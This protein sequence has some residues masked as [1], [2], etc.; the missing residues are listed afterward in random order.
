ME[1][2]KLRTTCRLCGSERLEEIFS[3]GEQCISAFVET[4]SEPI[5]APLT[6][7]ECKRC[8]LLQLKHTLSSDILYND[9]YG[10]KTSLNERMVLEMRQ[11]VEAIQRKIIL[12]EG[13]MVVDI[14]SNDGTL[15]TFYPTNLIRVGFDPVKKFAHEVASKRITHVSDYFNA[16][17][18]KGK[19]RVITAIAM[20]YDLDEPNKFLEDINEVLSDDG[21]F[22]IQQNYL[23]KM[24]DEATYDNISHEHLTYYSLKTLQ[25]LLRRHNLEVVDITFS[26]I[27]GGCFRTFIQKSSVIAPEDGVMRVLDAENA[28]REPDYEYFKR[29]TEANIDQIRD[30]ILGEYEKGKK[31]FILGASTRGNVILNATGLKYPI[32]QAASERNPEK[33]GKRILGTNIPIINEED[34]RKAKPDYFLVLPRWYRTEIIE[35][36]DKFLKEGGKL[37]F[38][39]PFGV[40]SND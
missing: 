28:E 21:L 25:E 6:L 11:I 17:W 35:R 8:H 33:W 38:P 19:A 10:Y 30:F 36:E 34:A 13:D 31:I 23:P 27:N 2:V 1:N 14:G 26:P 18:F 39:I 9:N 24:I 15:L 3:L 7:V 37:I 5:L 20:F 4:E 22:V 29:R 32:L 16:E 12:Q 40:V